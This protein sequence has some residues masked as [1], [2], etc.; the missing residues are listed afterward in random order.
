LNTAHHATVAAKNAR[1]NPSQ[2]NEPMTNR[3]KELKQAALKA[4]DIWL[5]S[6]NYSR[7]RR[8]RLDGLLDTARAAHEALE[9]AR[10]E[11]QVAR[12]HADYAAR[13]ARAER[14][15][16]EEPVVDRRSRAREIASA[17]QRGI[18]N[19]I[20]LYPER[21]QAAQESIQGA[22]ENDQQTTTP[23]QRN[24]ESNGANTGDAFG[25]PASR[26]MALLPRQEREGK[27]DGASEISEAV[28]DDDRYTNARKVAAVTHK[29]VEN[30]PRLRR[31]RDQAAQESIQRAN[32]TLRQST[33]PP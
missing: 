27:A 31:E 16:A 33:T 23:T 32:N 24:A 7:I 13:N 12:E 3:I 11:I 14:G 8:H 20:R 30:S 1:D 18:D 15:E 9:S 29:G 22:N 28:R 10:D 2:P 21:D 6:R 19:R 26:D 5:S 4:K 17:T 25:L